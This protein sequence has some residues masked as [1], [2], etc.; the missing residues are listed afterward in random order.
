M[1]PPVH[2]SAL[3]SRPP[4]ARET[5]PTSAQRNTR[6]T[7]AAI[8]HQQFDDPS[9]IG[10]GL[11]VPQRVDLGSPSRTPSQGHPRRTTPTVSN[12]TSELPCM[13]CPAPSK[14]ICEGCN[15]VYYCS[16]NCRDQDAL[17]HAL[18]CGAWAAGQ[19]RPAKSF[20]RAIYFP[21]SAA[22]GN[23][24]FVWLKFWEN[25]TQ[26]DI[27]YETPILASYFAG[28]PEEQRRIHSITETSV[29]SR[30]LE[31]T[32]KIVVCADQSSRVPKNDCI[33]RL[34]DN[35]FA[36]IWR[37]P[38]LAFGAN[39][40]DELSMK[41]EDLDISD[42]RHILDFLNTY[43]STALAK[44]M[45]YFGRTVCGVKINC[46]G[47]LKKDM[48]LEA[49]K[50][51]LLFENVRVPLS[52][53]L[54]Q[55]NK[56]LPI[57]E[58]MEIP[59]ASARYPRK[60]AFEEYFRAH[61]DAPY[62]TRCKDDYN[63]ASRDLHEE[64]LLETDRRNAPSPAQSYDH[65]PP[66]P[67]YCGSMILA[68]TDEK[69]LD[70]LHVEALWRYNRYWL[71]PKMTRVSSIHDDRDT[72]LVDQEITVDKFNL[73]YQHFLTVKSD[74]DRKTPS[75]Y[76]VKKRHGSLKR[77]LVQ[78]PPSLFRKR[79]KYEWEWSSDG[80]VSDGSEDEE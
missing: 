29:L 25:K 11:A 62:R 54:F 5:S 3:D 1:A 13:M 67:Y 50:G 59:I 30:D 65:A 33:A 79:P 15:A 21:D 70:A 69:P 38:V 10:A 60:P 56:L 71:E 57:P 47:D 45:R 22:D 53:R 24:Q 40:V 28:F 46:N 37:G 23:V 55:S 26:D 80:D 61:R 17:A 77:K 39:D 48:A 18:L 2:G 63:Q 43:Q 7:N 9:D 68:R 14:I 64:W 19:E 66:G 4:T 32:I 75:P 41:S 42:Y 49:L 44:D 34:V 31:R 35:R 20:R 58:R 72:A 12:S 78:E 27:D 6:P 51:H 73:Y 74:K 76:D 8:S 16:T 36:R 52:H